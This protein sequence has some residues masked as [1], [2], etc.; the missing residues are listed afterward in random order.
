MIKRKIVVPVVLCMLLV[1]TLAGVV[2]AAS[3]Q[4]NVPHYNACSSGRHLFFPAGVVH[5]LPGDD[6]FEFRLGVQSWLDS[7]GNYC[8]VKQP[9]MESW[10]TEGIPF[11]GDENMSYQSIG[12]W[13]G[14]TNLGTWVWNCPGYSG[15][16]L[17]H[18][19]WY[20]PD[21]HN[22]AC[23]DALY[24]T[25]EVDEAGGV[26]EWRAGQIYNSDYEGTA[27]S[28]PGMNFC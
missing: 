6:S 14:S 2:S 13:R 24:A 19:W 1:T 10:Q 3:A 20:G 21:I 16:I 4:P 11:A 25:G 15:C 22:V 8:G 17:K 12:I 5:K 26:G 18:N 28:S 7:S 23:L 9:V 27:T